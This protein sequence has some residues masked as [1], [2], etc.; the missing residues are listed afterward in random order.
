M[1]NNVVKFPFSVSRRAHARRP[2]KSINGTP[3]E[4]AAK[5]EAATVV[6]ISRQDV[7]TAGIATAP[8]IQAP[9]RAAEGAAVPRNEPTVPVKKKRR[10]R[11]IIEKMICELEPATRL[12]PH[13]HGGSAADLKQIDKRL[14]DAYVDQFRSAAVKAKHIASLFDYCVYWL[15]TVR[16]W[17]ED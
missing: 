7:A 2:R 13:V 12:F 9:A 3:E 6:E 5:A 4:R 14:A 8:T 1:M 17:P 15:E 10:R 16:S 11:Q